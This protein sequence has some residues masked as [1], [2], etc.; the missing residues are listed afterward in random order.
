[1]AVIFTILAGL[2]RRFVF[3]RQRSLDF[4]TELTTECISIWPVS[5]WF[6]YGSNF[7]GIILSRTHLLNTTLLEKTLS[8]RSKWQIHHRLRKS[9]VCARFSWK[10]FDIRFKMKIDVIPYPSFTDLWP[11]VTTWLSQFARLPQ[12]MRKSIARWPTTKTK[13]IFARF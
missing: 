5:R 2:S 7:L 8:L 10:R 11:S 9:A 1:M 13:A 3:S 4:P 12:S 6:Y